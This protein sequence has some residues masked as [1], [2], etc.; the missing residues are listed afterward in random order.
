LKRK[1]RGKKNKKYFYKNSAKIIKDI[2]A[3]KI[4]GA[5][6]VAK[7]ALKVMHNEF[8]AD[9]SREHID[10][11]IVALHKTRPT[12]PMMRN[13]IK[14]YLHLVQDRKL[15]PAEANKKVKDYFSFCKRQIVFHGKQLIK[16]GRTYF[17]H[18]HSSKVT[19]IFIAARKNKLFRVFNTETRPLFQGRITATELSSAG[20]PVV[21]FV[22]SA[23]RVALKDC[24]AVFIGADA[25]TDDAEVFNKIGSELIAET[26]KQRK[27]KVYVC[28]SSWKVDPM[29]FFDFSEKIEKRNEK[30]IWKNPPAGVIVNNFAFEKINPKF[31]TGIISE[32]G[33]LKPKEFIK[34]VKLK[35]KWVFK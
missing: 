9:S 32:F 31:I 12:E 8:K 11:I 34:K 17:T 18:C 21:H 29:T 30:E 1:K 23:A 4:Q 25:I 20:I 28:A 7:A 14:Y 13:T 26:A 2:K 16:D 22:D 5:T 6:S 3:L 19:G 35:N 33:I 15:K 27:I 10:K 24:D